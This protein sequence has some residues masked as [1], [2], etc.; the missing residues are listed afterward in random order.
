MKTPAQ[1][2]KEMG[3]RLKQAREKAGYPSTTEFCKEHDFPLDY[4]NEH[5]AGQRGIK[6]SYAQRYA[7]ALNVTLDWLILGD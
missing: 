1:I 6:V 3:E 4:Y 7:K 5:E 2:K